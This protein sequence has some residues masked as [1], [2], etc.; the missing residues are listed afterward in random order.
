MS[1]VK[2]GLCVYGV[3]G[4]QPTFFVPEISFELLVKRQIKRLED[5]SQRCAELVHEELQRSI[6]HCSSYSTPVRYTLHNTYYKT[7]T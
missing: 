4:P 6:Q 5:P 3:Q 2:R 7:F 1:Y